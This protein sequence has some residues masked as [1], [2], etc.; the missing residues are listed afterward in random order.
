MSTEPRYRQNLNLIT[1]TQTKL[2]DGQ[3]GQA[4]KNDLS[5][6]LL[7]QWIRI[8]L[9]AQRNKKLAFDN[10]LT[11]INLE[12]LKEAFAAIDGTKAK[13]VDGIDKKEYG[14]NLASNL[15]NL[16]KRIHQG[17]YKPRPKREVLIPKANGKTRPIAIACF[18]DKLVDWVVGKILTQVYEPLFIKNSFG[19]RPG[20]AATQAIE[21]CY[22]SLC[23]NKRKHVVEIDFSNFFNTIPHRKL[24]RIIGKR[25]SDRRFKGLIGRFLKG[26]LIN[27]DGENLPSAIGTPQ[28]SIMSPIL[29][30]IYLNEVIDQWFISHYASHDKI[31]VRYA[32]DAIFFFTEEKDAKQF[33]MD[34]EKRTREFGLKLNADKTR[35]LT[36]AKGEHQ[37]FNF[38]G[39][40]FYWGKQA[41][42]TLLKVKTQKEKLIKAIQE[43]DQ[44]IKEVRNTMKLVDIWKIAKAKIR[45]HNNYYGYWMNATKLNHFYH[46]AI[47][48]LFRWLNRRS[49]KR[50]YSWE[51]FLERLKYFPLVEPLSNMKLK[52]LGWNPYV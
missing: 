34:L 28:G 14:R 46:E 6:I 44:W 4:G 35:R 32:D 47:N 18:E 40:T 31:I 1:D 25:I 30:N 39:L 51:G 9:R 13:G 8:S 19:Y 36:I 11:H 43:F 23:K 42:R 22:Y 16:V 7:D 38:L 49:Q 27:A 24:M 2:S 3:N 41:S 5:G 45:G 20:K 48:S 10:L 52:Q 15:E 26:E 12:T 37:Q 29:A 21:A 50:S 17:S 33:L